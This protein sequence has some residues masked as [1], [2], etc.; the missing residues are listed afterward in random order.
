[1]IDP[2][3]PDRECGRSAPFRIR[4]VRSHRAIRFTA[5]RQAGGVAPKE[6]IHTTQ[7]V[8]PD[9]TSRSASN[10][11]GSWIGTPEPN[12]VRIGKPVV[13]P[14]AASTPAPLS[15]AGS[16]NVEKRVVSFKSRTSPC[17]ISISSAPRLLAVQTATPKRA[18]FTTLASVSSADKGSCV[19]AT[20]RP[21]TRA[22]N[23]A[24]LAASLAPRPAAT[25]SIS[26]SKPEIL[27]SACG[28][29]HTMR[30][31]TSTP[32]GLAGGRN[33]RSFRAGQAS[34][35]PSPTSSTTSARTRASPGVVSMTPVSRRQSRS[36]NNA[37]ECMCS[38]TPPTPFS[39]RNGRPGPVDIRTEP[40][41]ERLMAS[42]QKSSRG[43]GRFI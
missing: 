27:A 9:V 24:R 11:H 31:A 16:G 35:K 15:R 37:A 5:L 40:G 26:P 38:M 34:V 39:E 8:S 12:P 33:S 7:S 32:S 14:Q 30:R 36:R 23:E 17:S 22:R 19:C 42:R 43:R 41:K 1:M 29:S 28:A 18:P 25:I 13:Q 6:E 20:G 10:R 21:L 4:A 2:G 3:T